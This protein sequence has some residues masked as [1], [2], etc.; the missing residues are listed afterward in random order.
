MSGLR[1]DQQETEVIYVL[2][3]GSAFTTP[4]GEGRYWF[5]SKEAATEEMLG[6]DE[7]RVHHLSEAPEDF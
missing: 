5:D 3:D 7:F 4:D 6:G 1:R 2:P